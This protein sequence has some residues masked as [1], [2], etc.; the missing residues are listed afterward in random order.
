[1]NSKK[2]FRVMLLGLM[3]HAGLMGCLS[4]PIDVAGDLTGAAFDVAGAVVEAPFHLVNGVANHSSLKYHYTDEDDWDFEGSRV[5]S[6]HAET[7]NGAIIVEGQDSDRIRVKAFKE[8]RATSI[9]KAQEFC[10]KVE[11]KAIVRGER[12]EINHN[13]PRFPKNVYG[14]VRYEICV[15][16]D[17]KL[18]LHTVNGKV[19][20][21]AIRGALYVTTTN[22]SIH[23]NDYQGDAQMSTTN[24]SIA[25]SKINGQLNVDTTNASIKVE[26]MALLGPSAFTTT[27]GSVEVHVVDGVAPI[28]MKTTNGS[29]RLGLPDPFDGALDAATTNSSIYT[30]IPIRT[31]AFKAKHVIGELGKGGDARVELQ[32]TNGSI[33]IFSSH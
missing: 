6:I 28:K 21:E 30:D 9:N 11:V 16:H 26:E 8:I 31:T 5:S 4:T 24:G 2:M 25:V 22:G 7:V 18:D 23:V 14:S 17:M 27:N 33:R 3:M 15:P 1:M 32:T 13:P 19:R 20:V 10:D 12:L 29:I